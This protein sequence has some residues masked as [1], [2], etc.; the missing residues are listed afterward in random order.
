MDNVYN[1][2]YGNNGDLV[3]II[4]NNESNKYVKASGGY[5]LKNLY[6]IVYWVNFTVDSPMENLK[7][8]MENINSAGIGN[9][10][11]GEYNPRVLEGSKTMQEFEKNLKTIQTSEYSLSLLNNYETRTPKTTVMYQC[12]IIS[13]T[14]ESLESIKSKA[15]N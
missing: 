4:D 8:K 3:K 7:M 11:F 10:K 1:Y 2:K 6:S 14:D 15:S 9:K 13:Y 5:P 12:K